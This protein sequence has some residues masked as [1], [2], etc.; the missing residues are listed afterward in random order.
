MIAR[1]RNFDFTFW[2][3]FFRLESRSKFKFLMF[4][5]VLGI[6]APVSL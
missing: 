3:L 5:V 1:R 4:A 6:G 2:D